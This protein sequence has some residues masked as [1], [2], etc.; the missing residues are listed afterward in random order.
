ML[1]L[2]I[3]NPNVSV[4]HIMD[5]GQEF[6]N[7]YGDIFSSK[8]RVYTPEKYNEWVVNPAWNLGVSKCMQNSI[9]GILND[10]IEFNTD[11]FEWIVLNSEDIGILG[12]HTDNYKLEDDGEYK[13]IDIPQHMHGWGC[14]FFFEKRNWSIIPP[15]LKLY[16]GDTFQ[17]HSNEV[18]CKALTGLSMK[19][20]NIS[21]TTAR[22][23][24]FAQFNQMYLYERTWFYQNVQ[25][26]NYNL[27]Y[28]K[29][30]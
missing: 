3:Q 2:Y 20:S 21:A 12:M 8:I 25:Q 26:Q 13:I 17:F 5:N 6:H 24:F 27:G 10:D 18:P 15:D 29:I 11:I 1:P 28:E 23:E 30:Q 9:V 4:I 14:M 16:F 19:D 7:I 22:G